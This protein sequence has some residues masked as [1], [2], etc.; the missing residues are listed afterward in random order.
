MQLKVDHVTVAGASLTPLK[1]AFAKVGLKADYGGVHSNE[2]THMALLGLDDGSYLEMISTRQP[3]ALSPIWHR[4]IAGDAGL[5]AWA[6]EPPNLADEI[7]R[8]TDLGL[9]VEGPTHMTRRWPDGALAEWEIA[10][11]GEG[12]PGTLLPFLIKDRTPRQLRVPPFRGSAG[13]TDRG[14]QRADRL[15]GVAQVVLGVRNLD[16]AI[17]LFRRVYEFPEPEQLE[18]KAF[19]AMLARFPDTPVVLA[20]PLKRAEA[21]PRH[22]ED[23][24]DAWLEARLH[25]FGDVPTACLISV[26]DIELVI[27]RF[28]M[29]QEPEPWFGSQVAWFDDVALNGIRL[30]IIG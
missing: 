19:G 5:C 28:E 27:E 25:R 9:Q 13:G 15:G 23:D 22:Y 2:V 18:H 10:S 3:R 26:F 4:H 12:D 8:L 29:D 11:V 6:V 24:D 16:K 14:R 17:A 21:K 30:G 7:K 1:E 20:A